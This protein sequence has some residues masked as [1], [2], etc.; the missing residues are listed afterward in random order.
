MVVLVI[1]EIEY[2]NGAGY[3]LNIFLL[4]GNLSIKCI[5]CY[6]KENYCVLGINLMLTKIGHEF[7]KYSTLKII[8]MH[9]LVI[10]NTERLSM[11]RSGNLQFHL[12]DEMGFRAKAAKRNSSFFIIVK[13]GPA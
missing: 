2:E 12:M 8:A 3:F 7:R 13:N 6:F 9:N 10:K 11:K 4:I 5:Y 1:L